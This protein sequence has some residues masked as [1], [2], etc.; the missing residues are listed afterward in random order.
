M[1]KERAAVPGRAARAAKYKRKK[2]LSRLTKEGGD[3][4]AELILSESQGKGGP[5]RLYTNGKAGSNKDTALRKA[6]D[7]PSLFE[8][9]RKTRNNIV[10]VSQEGGQDNNQVFTGKRP[11]GA[12]RRH[13][14]KDAARGNDHCTLKR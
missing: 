13:E 7:S 3:N 11:P 5:D 6:E 14:A 1:G 2:D 12:T 4:R 9:K 10:V 8:K